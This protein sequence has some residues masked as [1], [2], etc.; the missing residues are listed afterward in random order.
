VLANDGIGSRRVDDVNVGEQLGLSG[1]DSDS[2]VAGRRMPG[3]STFQQVDLRSCRR[4]TFL[5]D[6]FADERVDERTLSRVEL[7]HDDQQKDLVELRN[8]R[9]QG[10]LLITARTETNERIANMREQL[11]GPTQLI[12]QFRSKH[13]HHSGT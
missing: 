10:A 8:R 3:F 11:T 6:V 4:D 12:L 7:A 9:G 2:A 5:Q 13:A 1:H